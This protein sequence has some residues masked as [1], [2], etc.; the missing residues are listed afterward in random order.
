MGKEH[1]LVISLLC[2]SLSIVAVHQAAADTIVERLDFAKP[3]IENGETTCSVSI[4]GLQQV[5]N[6]G[7][8]RLPAYGMRVLLPQG[9]EVAA[10]RVR[11]LSETEMALDLPLE[12][13]QQQS[14]LSLKRAERTAP[15]QSIYD[16][17][18]AFPAERAVHV[19]TETFRG[20]RIAFLRVYPAAYVGSTRSLEFSSS[21]EVTIETAGSPAGLLSSSTTLR[22]GSER[23]L[24]ALSRMVDDVSAASTYSMARSPVL[25]TSLTDPED[26]YPYVIITHSSFIDTFETL[27]IHREQMGLKGKIVN[28]GS[29]NF[30]YSGADLQEKIRNFIKDAYLNWDTEFVLLAGDDGEIPHRGLYADAGGGYT[31][32]DIAS[33][34]YYAALDG[35]WNTDG[36]G[37]WGEADEAD[38]IPE[39]SVGRAAVSTAD[40]AA[41]YVNKILKYET[42]PVVSQIKVGQMIGELLWS[43]P[44][45]GG[46]YKDEIKNGAATHG[47]TTVG[48]PPSFT[49]NTLYDR[50]LDPA[51]WDKEDLIPLLNGG[52]HLVNHLGHS[53]VTYGFRMYNSDV[54]TRFTNDGV[55]NS[56]FILYTQGCYS[57]SFD[58]RTS[59][60][61]YT[62][63][64]LGEHFMFIENGAVAFIGCTRYGWGQHASTDGANQYYDRQFFDAVFGEGIT[65]IGPANDDSKVDNIPFVDIGPNRWVYYELVLLGDPAMDIWTDTPGTLT[66]TAP[67]VIYAGDNEIE[68][69]VTDGASPVEGARVSI[70]N[71]DTYHMA[72]TDAAGRAYVNPGAAD[73]CSLLVTVSAHDFYPSVDTVAVI[74]ASH[75]VVVIDSVGIDDDSAGGSLGNSDGVIDAGETIENLVV[76]ANV[77]QDTALTVTAELVCTDPYI[78]LIDS[79]GSYGDIAPGAAPVPGWDFAYDVDIAAPDSHVVDFTMDIAH[80]DTTLVKHYSLMVSAP[81][82]SLAEFSVADT[83]YGNADGCIMPSETIELRLTIGNAGSGSAEGVSVILT[84][85]D[86]YVTLLSDSAYVAQIGGSGQDEVLPAFLFE[87][88]LECPDFHQIDFGVEITLAN[89]RQASDN[90]SIG[91]GGSLADD[92]EGAQTGWSSADFNDGYVDEWH[93]EDYRNNTA[94]GTYSWKFGGAGSVSYSNNAHGALVT[95]ELCLGPDATLTFWQWIDAELASATYAWDGGI[96][97][98]STDGSQTWSQITPVGGYHRLIQPNTASPFDPDTPCFATSSGWEE[99]EFDLSAYEGPARV[100]FRFGSD[101]SVR[102]EGW[103]IDDVNVTDDFAS[104]DIDDEDLEVRPVSFALRGVSPNPFSATGR[105]AFDVPRPSRVKISLY[106]VNGRVVDTIADSVYEPGQYSINLDY[107]PRLASGIYFISMQAEGFSRSNKVVVVR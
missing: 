99:V 2:I 34:L 77:G 49:V 61:T 14:P 41:N 44:T 23:D 88:A 67:D 94:G 15:E 100:R 36:D 28:I 54:E 65:A 95:P 33:D 19:T 18:T 82:L 104:V 1:L 35:N 39:V 103:Y 7:E 101:G 64:C 56:Y 90:L 24:Q 68:V 37:L 87:V 80:S 21:V 17:Q 70:F 78:S 66:V 11:L 31:D 98:I 102:E 107:G 73:P 74:V 85:S 60:R 30:N 20:Y 16:S 106:D 81:V 58:N 8:P 57:G 10:V 4:D 86:P 48:F 84:E 59:S 29:I 63:D 12:W 55:S 53:D 42:A 83:L 13:A 6:P 72:L 71:D 9:Q 76:L 45:W 46:D 47:Y 27:R 69:D 51:S 75:A 79:T 25:G 50:D 43:D 91:V 62:D 22:R 26:T 92:F 96:V 93:L 52:I 3:L 5:G 32:D 89:G 105:V 40:E 97:E 38:L